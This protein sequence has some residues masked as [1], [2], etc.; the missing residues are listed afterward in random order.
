MD[1]E[2]FIV[3][4]TTNTGE[5]AENLAKNML[6]RRLAGC[7]QV[8]GPFTSFYWWE[9]ELTK[10]KE[11]KCSMK[12][13]SAKYHNL[14]DEIR[15]THSYETPKIVALPLVKGSK[16]YFAWLRQELK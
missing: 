6:Q 1:T 9:G 11:W 8:E 13:N 15:K 3:E 4:T 14:E 7:V 5:E 12:T 16:S 2:F 10:S